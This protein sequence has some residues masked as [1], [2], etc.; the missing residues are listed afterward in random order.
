[1]ASTIHERVFGALASLSLRHPRQLLILTGILIVAAGALI[2]TLSVSTSRYGLVADDEPHQARMYRFFDRFGTP[3][4]PAMV[5]SGG[6]PEQRQ[7]VVRELTD[8]LDELPELHGRLMGR[9]GPA[10]AAEVLLLQR[11]DVLAEAAKQLPPGIDVAATISL[12]SAAGAGWSGR[13][14]RSGP[15]APCRT[16]TGP[17]ASATVSG[18][19]R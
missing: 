2:P 6:T 18:S 12:C 19:T 7:A 3:D 10:D 13:G 11:P 9:T 4:A 15:V 16:G 5:I 1:M 8:E 17:P 14:G